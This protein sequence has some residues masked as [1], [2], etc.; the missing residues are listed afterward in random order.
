[1]LMELHLEYR[2]YCKQKTGKNKNCS[3]LGVEVFAAQGSYSGVSNR[4]FFN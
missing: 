2:I 3:L 1:M 4:N